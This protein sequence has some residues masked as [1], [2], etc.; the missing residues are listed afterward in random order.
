MR[1][2]LARVIGSSSAVAQFGDL[3]A[4]EVGH[5]L[6]HVLRDPENLLDHIRK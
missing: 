6:L 1:K 2:N 3:Q 4:A 5:F